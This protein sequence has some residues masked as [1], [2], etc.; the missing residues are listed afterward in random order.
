MFNKFV[1]LAAIAFV[2]VSGC[3]VGYFDDGASHCYRVSETRMDWGTAQEV[4]L[5][6]LHIQ[7]IFLMKFLS[8]IAGAL[9][10]TWQS[11]Y[12]PM[13]KKRLTGC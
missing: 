1:Q 4:F 2:S 8:S 3:P 13:L 6:H 11:F 12:L 7:I 9:G 10:D 5:N